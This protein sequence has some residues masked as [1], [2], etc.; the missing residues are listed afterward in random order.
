V[1]NRKIVDY[2]KF[3]REF[4]LCPGFETDIHGLVEEEGRTG[5][6]ATCRLRG[7]VIRARPSC[8]GRATR[9]HRIIVV[10]QARRTDVS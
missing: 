7:P 6:C 4:A 1:F 10:N 9:Y 3:A 2:L 5:A 8:A